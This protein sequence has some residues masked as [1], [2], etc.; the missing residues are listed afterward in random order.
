MVIVFFITEKNEALQS[1]LESEM[2]ETDNEN[3]PSN[4]RWEKLCP[5]FKKNVQYYIDFENFIKWGYLAPI[6]RKF[7]H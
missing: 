2:R 6:S 4:I 3:N 7:G 5:L 1:S